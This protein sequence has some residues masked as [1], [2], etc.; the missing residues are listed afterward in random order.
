MKIRS[1]VKSGA[2]TVNHSQTVKRMK[3]KS[4]V[5]AGLLSTNHNRTVNRLKIKSGIRAGQG[6]PDP[7]GPDG[8]RG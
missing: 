1:R 7:Q 3:V 6:G 8:A 5:R 2:I 4:G